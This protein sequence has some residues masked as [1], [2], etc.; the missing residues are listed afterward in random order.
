MG[1]VEP[2]VGA[3]DGHESVL[4]PS[5]SPDALPELPPSDSPDALP[6]PPLEAPLVDPLESPLVGA[7]PSPPLAC[8]PLDEPLLDPDPAPPS[9]GTVNAAPP[10]RRNAKAPSVAIAQPACFVVL[11]SCGLDERSAIVMLHGAHEPTAA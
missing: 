6:E 2:A 11:T 7:P 1:H 5:D 10:H 8:A 4:P 9:V 3:S